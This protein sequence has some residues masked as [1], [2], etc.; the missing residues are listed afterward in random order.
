MLAYV[1]GRRLATSRVGL[2]AAALVAF[3]PLLVWFSQEARPYALLVL[4]SGLSFLFFAMALERASGWNLTGWA[5]ASGL[6][7]ATHYFAGLLI[8]P[9]LLWLV[10]RVRPRMR[11][12]PAL[13]GFAVVPLA[14]IPLVATQGRLQ[15]YSF[16]KGEALATRIFEQVPKQW[17]VG[18]DAPVETP[19]VIACAAAVLVGVCLAITS[20]RDRERRAALLGAAVGLSTLAIAL[21]LALL[22]A[23][24]YLSR[25]V[26][27][28]WLPL[29][30]VVAAGLSARRAGLVIAALL[31]GAWLFVVL[32]VNT[33]PEL[34]RDD[35]RGVARAMGV[36]DPHG[37]AI[38]ISPV[39]GN[40]PLRLYLPRA[41]KLT[42]VAQVGEI[43]AVA[44]APHE[45]GG[46]RK[47]PPV[48][49]TAP[50]PGFHEE[51]RHMGRTFT[52]VKY[53]AAAPIPITQTLIA[54]LALEPGTPDFLVQPGP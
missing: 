5:V 9:E 23:D 38:V 28:A 54:H 43:D 29:A 16:V 3:N 36:P 50:L 14:L 27:A 31:C 12:V 6:A 21:V 39:N 8:L 19:V 42:G 24:Y 48:P 33:R 4:L 1:I 46:T 20:L 49:R 13:A 51:S 26:L 32:S 18:Y 17:L 40:I 30:L 2:V 52:V 45:A 7:F 15:D 22:G 41:G 34:Q 11:L 47:A 37:R 10:Y 53:R 44:I 35:W 25:Y